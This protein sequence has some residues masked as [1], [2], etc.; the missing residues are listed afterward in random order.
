[1]HVVRNQAVR[2]M[3]QK[4]SD[5]SRR[6]CLE[7]SPFLYQR[8]ASSA[9]H[10]KECSNSQVR[11][12]R[13]LSSKK[14]RFEFDSSSIRVRTRTI[15]LELVELSNSRTSSSIPGGHRRCVPLRAVVAFPE[16]LRHPKSDAVPS[17]GPKTACVRVGL[18]AHDLRVL[19]AGTAGRLQGGLERTREGV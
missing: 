11:V 7:C 9:P 6:F 2:G 17:S 16:A 14:V 13:G 18:T 15:E 8:C 19:E 10:S 4:V 12:Q 3:H 1:M 5:S